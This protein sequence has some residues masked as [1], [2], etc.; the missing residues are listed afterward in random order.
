MNEEKNTAISRVIDNIRKYSI[1]ND[2]FRTNI[3]L[4]E[5]EALVDVL[6]EY[7]SYKKLEEQFYDILTLVVDNA[8]IKYK[9]TKDNKFPMYLINKN[10]EKK[11]YTNNYFTLYNLLNSLWTLHAF[12]FRNSEI[13]DINDDIRFRCCNEEVVDIKTL[14]KK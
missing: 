12:K 3:L 6:Y 9:N 14:V 11:F 1:K 13:E 10:G 4:Y 7:T 8:L 5:L 2:N